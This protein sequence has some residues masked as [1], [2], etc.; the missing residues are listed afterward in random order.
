MKPS[1]WWGKCVEHGP[2][3]A[4]G[5]IN[6]VMRVDCGAGIPA[7][8]P[9]A[10]PGRFEEGRGTDQLVVR[11]TREQGTTAKSALARNSYSFAYVLVVNHQREG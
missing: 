7:G 8:E 2:N 9:P 10:E 11:E 1:F 5:N 3:G 4:L 6:A